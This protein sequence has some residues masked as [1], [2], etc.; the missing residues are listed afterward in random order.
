MPGLMERA[1]HFLGRLIRP[2]YSRSADAIGRAPY[3]VK[4]NAAVVL[5]FAYAV[6]L[7]A[8]HV[9]GMSWLIAKLFGLNM[10]IVAACYLPFFAFINRYAEQ[11]DKL[12]TIRRLLGLRFLRKN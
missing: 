2:A 10:A 11:R 6:A 3:H 5:A 1:G 8:F 4:Y 7:W 9:L 12:P